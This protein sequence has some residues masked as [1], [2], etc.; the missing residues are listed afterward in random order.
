MNPAIWLHRTATRMADAPALLVGTTCLADY[1][2]FARGAAAIGAALSQRGIGAGDRVALFCAN[3]TEYLEA[4]YGIWWLGAVAVPINAKLHAREAAWIIG[5]SGARLVFTDNAAT[6]TLADRIAE[7]DCHG[8]HCDTVDADRPWIDGAD[9]LGLKE[10]GS[11]QQPG[12][13]RA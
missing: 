2:A 3:R 5:N 9:Q 4:L 6:A 1:G 13:G 11:V 7:A 8:K 12:A 10:T